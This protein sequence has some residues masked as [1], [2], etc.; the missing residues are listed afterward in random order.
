MMMKS[1]LDHDYCCHL[2]N[3]TMT[4]TS[5]HNNNMHVSIS[6]PYGLK[7]TIKEVP[8]FKLK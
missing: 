7:F 4:D 2:C 1:G 3:L 8:D 6:R 5:E